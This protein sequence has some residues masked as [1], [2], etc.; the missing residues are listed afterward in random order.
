MTL[1]IRTN[2]FYL[3]AIFAFT[4]LACF[5]SET[6][7]Q[8]QDHLDPAKVDFFESKIRPILVDHCYE[9]H[10][11]AANDNSGELRLDT[12][13]G[14]RK[15][16]TR[17]TSISQQG[18]ADS[19]LLKVILYDTPDMQ[20]PPA[21][22][23][24]QDKIDAIR[25][26][27]DSGAI[28]PRMESADDSAN[29]APPVTKQELAAK[30]W[31]FQPLAE[32]SPPVV[33]YDYAINAIDQL[34]DS[35]LAAQSVQ[36]NP[37]ATKRELI[38][39]LV[40][41]LQG[42]MPTWDQYQA[43]EIE[44]I[45][46]F[47]SWVDSMLGSPQFGERMAR[48]W[49][50]V[51]RYADNKGYVFM[52]DREYA[53]AWRYRQWLIESFNSDLPYDQ[54][55]Q[56]QLAADRLEPGPENRNHHA[57]GFL[58]LGRRF[59]NNE[60]DIADD[61]IDV[62]T[63]GLMGL[64]VTC[65]RCHDHKFDAIGMDDYY[66][67]HAA[68]VSSIE[69]KAEASPVLLSDSDHVRPAVIFK[70][71]NSGSRG[72]TVDKRFVKFLT[73]VSRPLETGSGRLEI[74]KSISDQ[75]NPL[76]PRVYVNRVWGWI[77]GT[78]LVDTP[79]D[80]GLRCPEPVQRDL[81]DHLAAEFLADGC[82]TKRLIKRIVMSKAYQRSSSISPDSFGRDPENKWWWRGNRK[83]MDFESLRDAM[84]VGT[85]QIDGTIGGPSVRI[86]EAPFSNRRTLYAYIDRQNLPGVFRSFDFASPEAHVSNRLSTTVPQQG[87]FMMNSPMIEFYVANWVTRALD[88]TKANEATPEQLLAKRYELIQSM[89]QSMLLK[90]ATDTE[91]N[92]CN[93]YLQAQAAAGSVEIMK[94]AW[95]DLARA[96]L[97]TN[98]FCF[99][100]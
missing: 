79:S 40:Y 85:K 30:H 41:D 78:P 84:L 55:V 97:C 52:E 63:R 64:T 32:V 2:L 28:D 56:F 95:V 67:M 88:E 21:G 5:V 82:S 7:A 17:G 61:R 43:L 54:F 94:L 4:T 42:W 24:P 39:R 12:A 45:E 72:D 83:R 70:R 38:R 50:D 53:Q 59:L 1:N 76:T 73:K 100:D 23:L 16:G 25:S 91:L 36:P 51:S 71:G 68:M 60:N 3:S 49:M 66:S 26:W 69:K 81:L 9:C 31:S 20:M 96:I 33:P 11:S 18:A 6:L 8:A 99:V 19:L 29:K 93:A 37:P 98:E 89:F 14:L 10:S 57:M 80:F 34:M 90:R 13:A 87:L 75:S 22:K 58:T 47:E 86:I 15:G 27:I 77:M 35:K 92:R 65:A 48:H 62:A 44:P 74:A 46:R